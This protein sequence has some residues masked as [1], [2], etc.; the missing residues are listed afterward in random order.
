MLVIRIGQ[1]HD[2]LTSTL[3]ERILADFAG[4]LGNQRQKH[5][6]LTAFRRDGIDDAAGTRLAI[7]RNQVVGLF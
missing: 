4:A 6:K 2:D 1:L 5:A 3:G 7:R